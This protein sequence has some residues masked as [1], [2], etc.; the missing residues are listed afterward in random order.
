MHYAEHLYLS[1]NHVSWGKIITVGESL[2]SNFYL[3]SC[4]GTLIA[5]IMVFSGDSVN[6]HHSPV[7]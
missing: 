4:K 7:A 2:T 1:S 3:Q 5:T 6:R